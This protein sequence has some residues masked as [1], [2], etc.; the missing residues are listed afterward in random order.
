MPVSYALNRV[1]L[2][3]QNIAEQFAIEI[4]VLDNEDSLCHWLVQSFAVF[5]RSNLYA[6]GKVLTILR[7]PSSPSNADPHSLALG[8]LGW[9]LESESRAER[10]LALTGLTPEELR[11]GLSDGS[12][13]SAVLDFLSSHEPDLV[14]AAEALG[15]K[16]EEL[17]AAR[18]RLSQ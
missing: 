2:T 16:P 5:T 1:A 8:A 4:V 10:L 12:M 14:A 3:S 17:I 9:V 7:D 11:A 6:L 15:V 13:L 18:E